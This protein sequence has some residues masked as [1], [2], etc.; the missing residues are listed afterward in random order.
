LIPGSEYQRLSLVTY[1]THDHPPLRATW[2]QLAAEA[3]QPDGE[4][5]QKEMRRLAEFANYHA[6][7]LPRELTPELHAAFLESLFRS[8]S[9]LAVVMITDLFARTE[10]F[11][12]PGTAMGANW[13]QRLHAPV[14]ALYKEPVLPQ[15]REILR[16]SGRVV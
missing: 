5:A 6:K 14:R 10:R 1:G 13:S 4:Y 11:N 15:L 12:L 7:S 8:N 9:Y 3:A 2:E 16:D